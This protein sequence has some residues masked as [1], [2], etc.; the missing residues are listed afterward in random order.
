MKKAILASTILATLVFCNTASAYYDKTDYTEA[1]Y[2][3]P[4]QSAFFIP[5]TGANNSG[6][7]QFGS[8]DYLVAN[9]VASKRFIIPHSKLTGSGGFSDYYVP[10]GR[11]I[12]VDRTPFFREWVSSTTRGTS[13]GDQGFRFE[14]AESIFMST[15]ITIAATVT[16]EDAA[17]FLYWF[18]TKSVTYDPNN[19]QTQFQSVIYG[20]SLAEVMD[21]VVRGKVQASLSAGFG[22]KPFDAAIG[23][24]SEIILQVEKEVKEAFGPKG[25]TIT[26]IGY[27]EGLSFDQPVQDA[28]N[29]AYI[30]GQKAKEA[31]TIAPAIPVLQM[32]TNIDAQR[33][34]AN[35]WNGVVPTFSGVWFLPSSFLDA[36]SNW[37][38][39]D[40]KNLPRS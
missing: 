17:K 9:K 12:V 21:T 32:Q 33:I 24:K 8:A 19:P 36:V 3:Q 28:L 34:I 18:G 39:G 13:S 37:F 5:D 1:V 35:K 29:A 26:Y 10:A 20:Q 2:I 14:S 15:G 7:A 27:A 31:A 4:N 16:E 23:K 25:I 6:Q 11:L 22:A 40:P 30:A 38:K